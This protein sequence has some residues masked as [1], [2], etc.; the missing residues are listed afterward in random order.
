MK[1]ATAN[2]PFC[3]TKAFMCL[4]TQ[5]RFWQSNVLAMQIDR[6]FRHIIQ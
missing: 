3:M 2:R 6:L 1:L 5:R 4:Q